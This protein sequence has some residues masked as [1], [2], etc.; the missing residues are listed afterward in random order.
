M[1]EWYNYYRKYL[2]SKEEYKITMAD[3]KTERTDARAL[4][5]FFTDPDKIGASSYAYN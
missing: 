4:F 1:T 3:G 5:L 2:D